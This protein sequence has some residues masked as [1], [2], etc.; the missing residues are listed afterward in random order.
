MNTN[1]AEHLLA[2]GD[3]ES[4]AYVDAD[5]QIT[6]AGLKQ[7]AQAY[8]GH[9]VDAGFKPGSN[10][11]IVADDSIA[12]V[13]AILG[14]WWVGGVPVP[15]SPMLTPAEIEFIAEDCSA[16]YRHVEGQEIKGGEPPEVAVQ[17]PSDVVLI[18]YTS[19]STG[20][21]KGVLHTRAGIDSVLQGFGRVLALTP[22]DTVLSTAKLSFGYGFGNSLLFPLTAGARTVL[23]AGPPDV[24]R[25]GAALSAHQPTVLFSVP[26]VYAALLER[27]RDGEAPGLGSLRLAVSAGE[28]LPAPMCGEFAKVCSAPLVNGLGATEVLHIVVATNGSRPGSTGI[29]VPGVRITVRDDAGDAVP[30]GVEGRLHVAGGSV[31]AGYLDRPDATARTFADGG[32]YTGDIVRRAADGDLE[33]VCRRD[34]VIN[35]GGFKVSPFEVEAAARDVDGLA[36]CAVVGA[37]DHSGLEQAVAYVVPANGVDPLALRALTRRAFKERLPAFKRPSVIEI[38]DQLPVTST[39]KLARFKLRAPEVTVALRVLR[40]G[41]GRTLVCIPYAGGSAGSFT[42]LARQL[43][44]S[45]RVV[46]GEASMRGAVSVADVAD[47]WWKAITPYLTDGTVLFGHSLGAVLAAEVAN[48]AG[49][50]LEPAHVVLSA[51]PMSA[52][53][54]RALR[55]IDDA[56]LVAELKRSGLMPRRR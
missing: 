22:A 24:F 3:P 25:V 11:L 16:A 52:G 30:D 13:V 21:P 47:A 32:A 38:V 45:W 39:G 20:T 55:A 43:P 4:T 18:Q 10:A 29:P 50:G 14:V 1:I 19:G 35:V 12:T 8:A 53:P 31:A 27:I 15:V 48:R 7:A 36:Q 40:E 6:Y 33:Y 56:E 5:G 51:P 34:D 54:A 44:A 28:H 41:R 17:E 46:A 23:S 2:A 9:L 37:R 26:R 49:A 42:R